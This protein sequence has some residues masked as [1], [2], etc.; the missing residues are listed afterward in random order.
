MIPNE[1][2]KTKDAI[3][4]SLCG[5]APAGQTSCPAPGLDAKAPQAGE[6]RPE[7]CSFHVLDFLDFIKDDYLDGIEGWRV[8][9]LFEL[10]AD[11]PA[12]DAVESFLRTRPDVE[13]CRRRNAGLWL[14]REP[15]YLL[16]GSRQDA[17]AFSAA[18]P[19]L[20]DA[21]RRE[22]IHVIG[23]NSCGFW[24]CFDETGYSLE[25]EEYPGSADDA[26]TY[27]Y[28]SRKKETGDD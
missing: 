15:T 17:K 26:A 24:D 18:A 6:K 8:F 16:I 9:K 11:R 23:G 28:V 4:A 3:R 1:T 13:Y 20:S 22:N 19:A 25:I 7:E 21:C 12:P 27:G 10:Q 5:N 14:F 2:E